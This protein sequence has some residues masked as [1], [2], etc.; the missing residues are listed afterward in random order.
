MTKEELKKRVQDSVDAIAGLS[1]EDIQKV[2][3][4]AAERLADTRADSD[5]ITDS[6]M[7]SAIRDALYN[8]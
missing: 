4:T 1:V 8:L 5:L 6:Y 7:L 3:M 2:W